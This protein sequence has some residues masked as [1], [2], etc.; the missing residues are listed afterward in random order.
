VPIPGNNNKNHVLFPFPFIVKTDF[1]RFKN[2]KRDVHIAA[3]I[4]FIASINSRSTLLDGQIPVST[5]VPV[6]LCAYV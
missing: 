4:V 1:V 2:K 3:F 6:V 5:M